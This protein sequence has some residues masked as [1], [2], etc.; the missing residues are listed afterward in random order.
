MRHLT[1]VSYNIHRGVGLDRRRDLDRIADVIG[2]LGPDVVGLQ[3]V[4]R[5]DG[6]PDADQAAY[7]A[8]RLEMTELVMGETRAHGSGIY[9]NVVLSRLPVLGWGRCD[10]SRRMREPR[11]CLRVDLDVDGTPLHLFNCH[12]GLGLRERREQLGLLGEFIRASERLAGPRVLLGDFNEW[13]RGPVT[14]GLRR[15]FSSPMRRRRTHPAM[16]PLFALDRIY[17]DAELE[18]EQFSVH[19]SRL[20]RVA[21]DHL[22]VVARLRVRHRPPRVAPYVVGDALPPAE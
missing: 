19:R 4:I 2:E 14:R 5:E 6:V 3:E 13:H 16:F 18:G 9:G 7:L 22:P 17:W 20:S 1:V 10:L 12:F 11:G 15:E 21:S 8:S